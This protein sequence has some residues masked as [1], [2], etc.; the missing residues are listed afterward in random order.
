MLL[1]QWYILPFSP[2]AFLAFALNE[3]TE[4]LQLAPDLFTLPGLLL[5]LT[6]PSA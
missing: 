4:P 1:H 5:P 3:E 2:P 6:L